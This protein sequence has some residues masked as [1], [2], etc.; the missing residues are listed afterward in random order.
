MRKNLLSSILPMK[1]AKEAR[2]KLKVY[3]FQGTYTKE[4]SSI[5]EAQ[6]YAT[7]AAKKYPGLLFEPYVERRI[8]GD[9]RQGKDRRNGTDRR[10]G[11]E[12]RSAPARE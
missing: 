4:F 1:N 5:E 10:S 12:R 11:A 7:S 8:S 2:A 3:K 9:R 6:D